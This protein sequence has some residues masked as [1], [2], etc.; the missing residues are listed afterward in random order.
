MAL[1][2]W[3]GKWS[4]NS[5]YVH[6]RLRKCNAPLDELMYIMYNVSAHMIQAKN[7]ETNPKAATLTLFI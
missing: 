4:V 3:Y 2:Y 6:K 7:V 1:A 5:T